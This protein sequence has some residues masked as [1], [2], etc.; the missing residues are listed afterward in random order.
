MAA[1]MVDEKIPEYIEMIQ[2]SN[3]K[4][5][6]CAFISAKMMEMLKDNKIETIHRQFVSLNQAIKAAMPELSHEHG[7]RRQWPYWLPTTTEEVKRKRKDRD[8]D[9]RQSK[10]DNPLKL[11]QEDDLNGAGYII[12][13][14]IWG[15]QIGVEHKIIPLL[16]YCISYLVPIR[17]NDLNPAFVRKNGVRPGRDTYELVYTDNTL[18]LAI[19]K[20]SKVNE[21]QIAIQPYTTVFIC[22]PCH[23]ALIKRA[24]DLLQDPEILNLPTY[25]KVVNFIDRKPCG[26]LQKP[27]VGKIAERMKEELDFEKGVDKWGFFKPKFTQ[28]LARSFTASCLHDNIIRNNFAAD[29][30]VERALGHAK[31]SSNNTTYL[32]CVTRPVPHKGVRLLKVNEE[33]PVILADGTLITNGLKVVMSS[34]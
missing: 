4:P 24:I 19:K 26:P 28:Q 16:L 6:I 13:R 2:E 17:P 27:W 5:A 18:A 21:M 9:S 32:K 3:D 30:G 15:L 22:K 10:I 12:E 25:K 8:L 31:N 1:R 23:Y 29:I 34:S 33:N 20:P 7:G 14:A 11:K